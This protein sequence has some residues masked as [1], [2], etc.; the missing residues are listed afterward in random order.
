MNLLGSHQVQYQPVDGIDF[1]SIDQFVSMLEQITNHNDRMVEDLILNL[2][3]CLNGR[4]DGKNV[5]I[6]IG[7]SAIQLAT[8]MQNILGDDC[9][10]GDVNLLDAMDAINEDDLIK[11]YRLKL[12]IIHPRRL[13]DKQVQF[14]TLTEQLCNSRLSFRTLIVD[15]DDQLNIEITT[16]TRSRISKFRLT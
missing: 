3:A 6:V 7:A 15:P 14:L 11:L 13:T 4:R 8:A 10:V 5:T 9:L 1:D 2:A 12:L 16:L